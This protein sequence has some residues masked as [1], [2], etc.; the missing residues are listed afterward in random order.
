MKRKQD[1][2]RPDG[3]DGPDHAQVQSKKRAT[4]WVQQQEKELSQVDQLEAPALPSQSQSPPAGAEAAASDGNGN[5]SLELDPDSASVASVAN[6]SL[7]HADPTTTV[8]ATSINTTTTRASRRFPS[9]LKTIRCTFAGCTKT[10]NRPA[11]LAAHLR[12]HTNDRP[13]KCPYDDCDK[14]YL[15]EKHLSQHIKGS[16]TN[17]RKYTCPEPGCGKSFVTNT[18]LRRHALVHEGADR[19]RCRGYGDCVQS[20]RKH[21]TLQRHIRTVHLGKSAYPCGNDGCDAGFDTASA[22]RRH[23][24]REHGD[25]KFWCDECNAEGEGDDNGGRRVGFTTMLL[26]QAHMKKEHNNCAFCGIRCGTQ[27]NMMR[28]VELYHSAKTVE[29]RKTIACTWEGC[30]KK[31]T[32]V[33]NLNTHIKSAHEGHRFVCGQTDT[34]DAKVS[35]IADW[36]FAEEGCGQGFTTRVKLEEHVLHVHLGKKRP[37]KLY[38]VPSMV[39]QT[40]QAQQALLDTRDL[41]CPAL[42]PQHQQGDVH[43]AFTSAG[44]T[45]PPQMEQ[46]T[47]APVSDGGN[48]GAAP[49]WLSDHGDP[50]SLQHQSPVFEDWAADMQLLMGQDGEGSDPQFA[51]A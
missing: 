11:R 22:L 21:Q 8:A 13:F 4:D 47:N 15:E 2:E 45:P 7:T 17:D 27:S 1:D 50:F 3:H 30:D 16:H 34:Y 32:R 39:A 35:E 44:A 18:R 28:H 25:L 14:D 31:F 9:D 23:V 40:Q 29:D 36:N 12:S 10:F 5:D 38:P 26:L 20:F 33:S 42:E 43:S 24:E 49:F 48:L 6:T 41:A 46:F 19:Y 51:R 37:P